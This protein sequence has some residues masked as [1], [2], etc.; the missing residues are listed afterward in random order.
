MKR[1]QARFFFWLAGLRALLERKLLTAGRP[2]RARV[3]PCRRTHRRRAC[4]S[5]FA[6]TSMSSVDYFKP[7]TATELGDWLRAH[8]VD[9][10]SWGD[11]IS[12]S[13]EQLLDEVDDGESL[14]TVEGGRAL[15]SVRVVSVAV[16]APG[17]SRVLV[18]AKQT[19]PDGRERCRNVL[20]AE[21][22]IGSE[23]PV[24]AARRGVSE[25]LG[26][27]FSSK[28]SLLA[29]ERVVVD[30]D[31]LQTFVT[32]HPSAVSYPG[33]PCRYTLT[34]V[35]ATVAGLPWGP[36]STTEPR[37]GGVL[38]THWEWRDEPPAVT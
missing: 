16:R 24:A 29:P 1:G 18:E 10:L 38:R 25:E 7:K 22:L 27:A 36:F 32:S 34:R 21:K 31:S 33:L 23:P 13:L 15:R 14:L 5:T 3:R 26:S 20:L 6:A 4:F 8:G 19:F 17:S 30:E 2:V 12:K 28:G 11:G 9:P 37:P 35:N